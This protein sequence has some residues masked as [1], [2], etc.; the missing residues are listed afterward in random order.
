[1]LILRYI[2]VGS[3]SHKAR[4]GHGFEPRWDHFLE[5]FLIVKSDVVS[6][7]SIRVI[8]LLFNN[9]TIV[10]LK[11]TKHTTP[12]DVDT[13]FTDTWNQRR[14]VRVVLDATECGRVSL[15]KILSLK[16]VLNK[17]RC[18]SRRY[19]E[20]STILLK[21][22]FVQTLVRVGLAIIGTERPVYVD[23]V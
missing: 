11:I 16:D 18:Y 9:M 10:T 15:G 6:L 3:H 12:K 22:R 21:S 17:H 20:H 14:R 7:I 19:I 8:N 5:C 13:F 23:V 2:R 1:M 4:Q